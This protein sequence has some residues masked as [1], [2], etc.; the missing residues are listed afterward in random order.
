MNTSKLNLSCLFLIFVS[1]TLASSNTTANPSLNQFVEISPS[2]FDVMVHAFDQL[3]V[4][5]HDGYDDTVLNSSLQR[6]D[7]LKLKINEVYPKDHTLFG[8]VNLSSDYKNS[9][10]KY[11]FKTGLHI[12]NKY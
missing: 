3:V 1:L 6:L 7:K 8:Y 9:L 11:S 2:A 12:L 10:E 4:L 5:F